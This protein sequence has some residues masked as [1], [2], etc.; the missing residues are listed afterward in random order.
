MRRIGRIGLALWLPALLVVAWWFSSAAG[1]NFFFPP[2]S[3]ILERFQYNFLSPHVTESLLPSLANLAMGFLLAC[4]AGIVLGVLLGLNAWVR[5][6]VA[7][8]VHFFRSLPGPALLPLFMVLFGIG[9][10][11]KVL[12]I[13]FTAFFVVLLNTIDGV[14]GNEP[15]WDDVCR[16]YQVPGW[17]RLAFVVVPGASPQ[18]MTG[19]RVGLQVSLLLMVVS[20]MLASTGGVG[21]LILQSQQ[22]FKIPDMWAGIIMLGLLGFLLNLILDPIE[23]GILA[24]HEATHDSPAS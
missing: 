22:Q 23:R 13:A 6:F 7:P 3:L 17:R 5:A 1:G 24:W 18:I 8:G 10:E 21:F 15:R 16:S 4:L 9:V 11:M 19:V 14:Q 20:E 12:I 2:L